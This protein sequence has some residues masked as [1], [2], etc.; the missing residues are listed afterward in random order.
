MINLVPHATRQELDDLSEQ[1]QRDWDTLETLER[2]RAQHL[3]HLDALPSE[4][5]TI[6]KGDVDGLVGGARL[7]F[8]RLFALHDLSHP[9][10]SPRPERS[11]KL[12]SVLMDLLG[13]GMDRD[14]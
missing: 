2:M 9:R 5:V 11:A 6:R 8:N 14:R 7:A 1:L 3:I 4:D 10:W 12:T 13:D